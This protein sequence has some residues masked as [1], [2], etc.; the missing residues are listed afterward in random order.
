LFFLP[1]IFQVFFGLL[2]SFLHLGHFAIDFTL[3]DPYVTYVDKNLTA[4]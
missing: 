4:T 2:T 1:A 3:M